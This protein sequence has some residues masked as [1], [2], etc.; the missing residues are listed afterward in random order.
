MA[1]IHGKLGLQ[2]G[3]RGRQA[4]RISRVN[5]IYLSVSVSVSF[6]LFLEMCSC[7]NYFQ[8]LQQKQIE[9]RN[10]ATFGSLRLMCL[11]QELHLCVCLGQM[12]FMARTSQIFHNIDIYYRHTIITEQKYLKKLLAGGTKNNESILRVSKLSESYSKFFNCHSNIQCISPENF[13]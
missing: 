9:A 1:Q 8:L 10:I 11:A 6:L 13:C 4:N 3:G 5:C 2:A 7:R 12:D